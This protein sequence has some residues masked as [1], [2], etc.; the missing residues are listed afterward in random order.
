VEPGEGPV[1]TGPD[2]APVEVQCGHAAEIAGCPPPYERSGTSHK[3]SLGGPCSTSDT[4]A[5][6]TMVYQNMVYQNMVYHNSQT[7]RYESHVFFRG[8]LFHF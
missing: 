8:S 6:Y 5:T 4:P 1:T 7:L 3:C 2:T